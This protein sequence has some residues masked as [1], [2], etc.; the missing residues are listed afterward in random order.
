MENEPTEEK[1]I[2]LSC[3]AAIRRRN[4]NREYYHEHKE[5]VK[6]EHCGNEYSC[7]S[8]LVKHQKKEP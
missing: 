1:T 7:K 8:G 6:C 3:L 4:Y 5:Q 2:P